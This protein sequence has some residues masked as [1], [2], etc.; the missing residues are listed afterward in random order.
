MLPKNKATKG[1]PDPDDEKSQ[2][3]LIGLL[4][5]SP[6]E[7]DAFVTAVYAMLHKDKKPTAGAAR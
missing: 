4:G 1:L 2:D 3:T 5:R 6:D 7:A